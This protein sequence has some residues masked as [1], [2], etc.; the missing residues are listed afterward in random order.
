MNRTIE[1]YQQAEEYIYSIPKFTKKNTPE[2]TRYFYERLGRPGE[3]S[4]I[5]HI[6][7]TNGKGS[8][9]AYLNAILQKAGYHVGMFT[10]PHLVVM[11]ERFQIDSKM[12]K[13]DKFIAAFQ[14]VM[15]EVHQM[16]KEG[17]DYHPTFFEI[18]FFIGMLLFEEEKPDYMILETGLGGRLDATNVISNPIATVITKIGIDHCEYLGNTIEEIAGEKAGIIKAFVPVIYMDST[19]EVK[20]VIEEKAKTLQ[21]PAYPV[22]GNAFNILKITDKSIDFSYESKYYNNIRLT[23]SN[24]ALYQCMNVALAIHTLEVMKQDMMIRKEDIVEAVAATVW[25]GRMEEVMPGVIVD[26]AHN[27]DGIEAFVETVKAV[28]DAKRA[29]NH[30]LFAVV[31][32]KDY[33]LMIK[34]LMESGLFQD[35]T[36]TK[37]AGNREVELATLKKIFIQY[38]DKIEMCEDVTTAFQRCLENRKKGERLY[39]VGSLYLVGL[40]KE[41]IER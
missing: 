8:V 30:L 3:K 35:V 11:L 5:I 6:A 14:K 37:I 23:L 26:G 2:S 16:Q 15:E 20:K 7:G 24:C 13:E 40:V 25:E 29:V 27:E 1:N 9:C 4:K 19:P 31:N 18:L 22:S 38:T 34:T 41:I 12:V 21:S 28:Q 32:D 36:I 33:S 39:I 10:S 17:K